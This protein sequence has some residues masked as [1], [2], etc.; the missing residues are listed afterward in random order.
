[1]PTLGTSADFKV[2]NTILS[3]IPILKGPSNYPIWSACIQSTLQSLSVWEFINGSIIHDAI[4]TEDQIKWI[5]INKRV[6]DIIANTLNDSLLHNVSY[7]HAST[8][9]GASF[10]P[11]VTKAI[12]DKMAMLFDSQGLSGQFYLFHQALSSEICTCSANEDIRWINSFFKQMTS[13]ELD[14]PTPFMQ[15]SFL[16]AFLMIS[17]PFAQ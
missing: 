13:T 17:F 15:C 6:C 14:L 7:E 11:S 16:L 4:A 8:A 5:T 3:W 2:N 1:M 12:W 10:H 9:T